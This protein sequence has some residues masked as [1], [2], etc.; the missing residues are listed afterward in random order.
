M[1]F[2]PIG[3]NCGPAVTLRKELKISDIAL[4]FDYIRTNFQ[5]IIESISTKFRFFLPNTNTI[6]DSNESSNYV[7]DYDHFVKEDVKR[8]H[9]TNHSFW[10]HNLEDI[11]V[12]NAFH[13]RFDRFNQLLFSKDEIVFIRSITSKIIMEEVNQN[14]LFIDLLENINPNL[15]YKLI[16]VLTNN[17][18][19]IK[20]KKINGKCALIS[21]SSLKNAIL[22]YQK[23]GFFHKDIIYDNE[24]ITDCQINYNDDDINLYPMDIN[25]H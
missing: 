23:F 7:G 21:S 4:P 24:N 12:I 8:Y 14:Q 5:C 13:R 25:K 1:I 19:N 17:D 15:N 9:L 18:N 16:F 6:K 22:F 11:N 10:H 20:Y 3:G 2:V